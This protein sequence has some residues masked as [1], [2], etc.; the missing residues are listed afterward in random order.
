MATFLLFRPS[1]MRL[2]ISLLPLA[3][4]ACG[5]EPAEHI[6]AKQTHLIQYQSCSQLEKDLEDMLIRE[7]H[8]SIDQHDKVNTAGE[9]APTSDSSGGEGG[10]RQ[11]GVDYSG[12]NNQENGVD[13]ADM[14][15]TDGYHIYALNGNRD[16]KSTRL[17]SSH[18]QI[19]Y[20]VFCLK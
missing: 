13:E 4:V 11:E 3:L 7:V 8:A 20:A 16:R 17:N 14:V 1:I 5:G 6:V 15:K 18:S 10:G 9:D 2:S 19:S 12:T